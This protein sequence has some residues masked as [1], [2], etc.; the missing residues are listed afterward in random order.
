MANIKPERQQ[1]SSREIWIV[2]S[3]SWRTE[4]FNTLVWHMLNIKYYFYCINAD[5]IK[6]FTDPSLLQQ[7]NDTNMKASYFHITNTMETG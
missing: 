7:A 4:A 3:W 2:H 5:F 6:I 1:E